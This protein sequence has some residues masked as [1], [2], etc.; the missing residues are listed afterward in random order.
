[1]EFFKEYVFLAPYATSIGVIVAMFQIW[2]N[3]LQSKTTFEDSISKEYREIIRAIPYNALI[4]ATLTKEEENK[5]FNEIYNYMDFCNE[6][7]FLRKNRRIRKGTWLNWQ[8]GMK[9]NFALPIFK[10]ASEKVF[11][12]LSDIFKELRTVKDANFDTDPK[13]WK[14]TQRAAVDQ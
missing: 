9:M 10:I 5:V 2:R 11:D 7:I 6:Q 3:T 12:D 13:N 14:K 4:G 8:S 1:M